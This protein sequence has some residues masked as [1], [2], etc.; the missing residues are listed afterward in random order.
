MS[1]RAVIT[2][3]DCYFRQSGLCALELERP[4]PTFRRHN[5]G[6][7]VPPPQA[8]L[9]ARTGDRLAAQPAAA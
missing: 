2:C 4:C 1:K 3:N 9:V 7:L 5:R 6:L 8:R